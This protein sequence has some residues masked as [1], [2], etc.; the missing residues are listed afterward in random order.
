MDPFIFNPANR[1]PICDG[2]LVLITTESS[3]QSL[4]P[5]ARPDGMYDWSQFV[6]EIACTKCSKR[7]NV[8]SD[9]TNLTSKPAYKEGRIINEIKRINKKNPFDDVEEF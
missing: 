9:K 7:F 6:Q 4:G 8:I 2:P 3:I 1:C 5:D